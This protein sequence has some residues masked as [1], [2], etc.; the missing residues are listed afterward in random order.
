MQESVLSFDELIAG[1]T[2]QM[3]SASASSASSS[4]LDHSLELNQLMAAREKLKARI[5]KSLRTL[6]G[7]DH[8]TAALVKKAF[9]ND[10]HAL[11][12]KCRA[13]LGRIHSKVLQAKF[14]A[15]PYERRV[16]QSKG[17]GCLHSH[18]DV[19]VP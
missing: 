7:D 14:A 8:A 12:F 3:T 17:G 5:T 2:S 6:T 18:N 15:V 9:D 4:I 10:I 16:S 11:V 13:Y 1:I 19:Q